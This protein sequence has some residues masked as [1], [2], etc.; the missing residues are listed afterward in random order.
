MVM[1]IVKFCITWIRPRYCSFIAWF[2]VSNCYLLKLH[3]V[4]I[5]LWKPTNF[6]FWSLCPLCEMLK[7]KNLTFI[8][9]GNKPFLSTSRITRKACCSP[10]DVFRIVK[11]SD[12]APKQCWKMVL[13][14]IIVLFCLMSQ[15]LSCL[16]KQTVDTYFFLLWISNF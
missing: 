12:N 11:V 5:M 16:R 4:Y 9:H 3:C 14:F 8:I 7:A 2:V 13:I 15:L 10:Y 6:L 1:Y